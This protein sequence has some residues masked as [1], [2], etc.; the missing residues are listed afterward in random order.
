[1]SGERVNWQTVPHDQ[2][3]DR[4]CKVSMVRGP[5]DLRQPVHYD[6][7]RQNAAR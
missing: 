2:T 3:I 4:K 7:S 6:V 5:A 1:M